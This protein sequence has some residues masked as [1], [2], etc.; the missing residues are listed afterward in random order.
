MCVKV[1]AL[2]FLL[3]N[4]SWYGP[5][6][7]QSDWLIAVPY[8]TI[9]TVLDNF[10]KNIHFSSFCCSGIRRYQNSINFLSCSIFGH[11]NTRHRICNIWTT[12]QAMCR[13]CK[14]VVFVW[15][16]MMPCNKRLTNRVILSVRE[17]RSPHFYARPSQARAVQKG[18]GF[19]FPRLPDRV[20]RLVNRKYETGNP[21]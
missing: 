6:F 8:K 14:K 9:R 2:Y 21:G 18:S 15:K 10:C 3:L 16:M 1:R 4:G 17:I 7:L 20:T 13:S 11:V 19:V 5:A 12:Y